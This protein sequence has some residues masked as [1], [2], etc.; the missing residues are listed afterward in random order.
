M[1]NLAASSGVFPLLEVPDL[2]AT[3]LEVTPLELIPLEVTP[4]ELTPFVKPLAR[5]AI[6]KR[7]CSHK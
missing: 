6:S 2:E 1:F 7:L 4:L 5:G 3:P